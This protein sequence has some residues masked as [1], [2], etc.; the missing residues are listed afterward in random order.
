MKRKLILL[1]DDLVMNQVI[2]KEMLRGRDVVLDT[3]FN[4]E[5]AVKMSGL[6]KYDIILMDIQM[7]LMNGLE[8]A[9]QIRADHKNPNQSTVIIA[10]SANAGDTE[11]SAFKKAG[12][13]A[14]FAKPYESE[15]LFQLLFEYTGLPM[16]DNS[17][18]LLKDNPDK[19]RNKAV[20][21]LTYLRQIGK[22]NQAFIGMMLQS[23][24]DS[25]REI[26]GEMEQALESK[27]WAK[28]AQ[29][30]HKLK[31]ALNVM[32]AGS[33]DEE[34][35]WIE[36]NTRHP[37]PGTDK[38]IQVRTHAFITVIK[39]LYQHAGTLIDSGEWN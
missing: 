33:L 32:G 17:T 23:F 38:E 4:G 7:P 18:S 31:F 1:A 30:M 8:A 35:R 27:D 20:V 29:L 2:I 22:N 13:N 36:T 11:T 34:V 16:P 12:M 14:V 28:T 15:K 21:D 9:S 10:F 26:I 5:E 25:A 39:E 19:E 37:L 3:A 24:R 6:K